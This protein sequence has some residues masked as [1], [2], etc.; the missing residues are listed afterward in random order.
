ME[1]RFQLPGAPALATPK[2]HRQGLF[3]W[4]GVVGISLLV[5]AQINALLSFL[6]WILYVLLTM[7]ITVLPLTHWP[8]PF[9]THR[10][11]S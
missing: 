6:P 4:V 2:R 8:M 5:S 3:V 7:G 10:F 9:L 11:R 1:A